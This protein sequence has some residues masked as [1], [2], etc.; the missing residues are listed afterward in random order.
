MFHVKRPCPAVSTFDVA[1]SLGYGKAW[2]LF[3]T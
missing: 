1:E 2:M 3:S